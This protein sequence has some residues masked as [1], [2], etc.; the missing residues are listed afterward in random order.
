MPVFLTHILMS[1]TP[2]QFPAER[3]DVDAQTVAIRTL[4]DQ[5]RTTLTGGRVVMTQGV[6]ALAD[7]TLA[8]VLRTVNTFDDFTPNNDPYG[9]HEF[10]MFEVDDAR[11][12]FKIDAYDANLE[13][14][15]PNPG[16]P[17]VTRRV[18]TILLASEY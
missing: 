4:N 16:D 17:E 18:M 15:S 7:D 5:L 8:K 14:G 9:T 10:G 1:D 3:E 11:V 2:D 6:N 12:M 13:Y